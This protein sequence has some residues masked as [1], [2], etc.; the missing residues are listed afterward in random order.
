MR[1]GGV[2]GA[3]LAAMIAAGAAG[4][5]ACGGRIED[6]G[7]RTTT[8]TPTATATGTATPTPT[9]PDTPTTTSPTFDRTAC[10]EAGERMASHT[11]ASATRQVP[12]GLTV[13]AGDGTPARL[14]AA[15]CAEHCLPDPWECPPGSMQGRCARIQ[16]SIVESGPGERVLSCFDGCPGGRRP[17]GYGGERSDASS[18]LG[19]AFAR[20]A[21]LETV[22]IPAFGRLARE[23]EAHGC[24]PELARRA[25]SAQRDEVRHARVAW[26][27]ARRFGATPQKLASMPRPS[28]RSRVELAI[29]NVAE[30]CVREAYG[31]VVAAHQ[32][33]RA[34]DPEVRRAM[35]AIAAD[36]AEHAELAWAVHAELSARLTPEEKRQVDGAFDA[37]WSEL[38]RD[39]AR[40]ECDGSLREEAGVP[41]AAEALVA[42]A[43]LEHEVRARLGFAAAA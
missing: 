11:C 18:A 32:A 13:D 25:R 30:G 39:V 28:A 19:R 17:E 31:A 9:R 41:D 33:A 10:G 4:N 14:D 16:C 15:T 43:A 26:S 21:Q 8:T 7:G 2:V 23:L 22:S 6:D 35:G 36:E 27:L 37:A 24:S 5:V 20:L 29:E 38:R 42:I 3:A 34:R 40:A 12:C 1:D